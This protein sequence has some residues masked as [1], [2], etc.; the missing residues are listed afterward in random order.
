MN[1]SGV[2]GP[3]A[4][5]ATPR[6]IEREQFLR[7]PGV[8]RITPDLTSA[9]TLLPPPSTPRPS[10]HSCDAAPGIPV[11]SIEHQRSD[12]SSVVPVPNG[13]PEQFEV[14]GELPPDQNEHGEDGERRKRAR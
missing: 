14:D 2:N 13:Q 6:T 10:S 4:V 12:H 7:I 8:D 9:S 5:P 3:A 1:Q 11:P